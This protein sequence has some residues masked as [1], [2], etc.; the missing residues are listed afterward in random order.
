MSRKRLNDHSILVEEDKLER[1][2][3]KSIEDLID[4]SFNKPPQD[5]FEKIV[6]G[7]C[8]QK[9]LWTARSSLKL[10]GIVMLSHHSKGGHLENLAVAPDMRGQGIGTQLIKKLIEDT[11]S[12]TPCLI[13]LT[14]RIPD[15]FQ[16]FGF[17]AISKL[18]DSS[19]A[20]AFIKP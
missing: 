19:T 18:S 11:S 2:P 15:Y 10:L 16:K 20:M 13:T 14:T 5:V 12:S 17:K 6:K 3:W 1:A 8:S 9:R 7:V 4:T